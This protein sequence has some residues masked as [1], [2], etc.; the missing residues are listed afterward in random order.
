MR[1]KI[2]SSCKARCSRSIR[3]REISFQNLILLLLSQFERCK[4]YRIH[5]VFSGVVLLFKCQTNSDIAAESRG[6]YLSWILNQLLMWFD[7]FD[8]CLLVKWRAS[9]CNEDPN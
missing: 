7:S 6:N 5:Y 4:C 8:R 2:A 1:I 3:S 9:A